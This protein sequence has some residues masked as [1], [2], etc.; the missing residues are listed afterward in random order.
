MSYI[1]KF[2]SKLSSLAIVLASVLFVSACRL[3]LPSAISA[4]VESYGASTP[5]PQSELTPDQL[6]A[7]SRWFARHQ[8]GWTSSP[9]SY[10]PTLVVRVK[11][12]D[13]E[14]SVINVLS[15]M[16]V[17]NNRDGQQIQ[18]LPSDELIALRRIL[19]QNQR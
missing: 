14:T 12:A 10:V 8:T 13:G 2:L 5:A 6:K 18:N 9:A 15:A 3:E 1:L 17:V 19:G 7:L 11:H 4:T 16:V